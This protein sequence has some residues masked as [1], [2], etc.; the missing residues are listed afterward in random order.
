MR[1]TLQIILTDFYCKRERNIIMMDQKAD[2]L[3]TCL[4]ETEW[5][6]AMDRDIFV[7][8]EKRRSERKTVKMI[9]LYR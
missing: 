8:E 3:W 6:P 5:K 7:N 1:R 4:V 9:F 2:T